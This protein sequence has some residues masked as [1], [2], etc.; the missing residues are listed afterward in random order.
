M[1]AKPDEIT[2]QA[3]LD[4]RTNHM[5][6]VNHEYQRGGV[7]TPAQK[8]RLIDSVL[9]GYPLPLI[10]F[11]YIEQQAAGFISQRLEVI[12][13][14]QRINAL[15]DYRD[16][17]FKLFDP[18]EDEAA[19]RFPDFIKKQPCAWGRKSFDELS[20]D[21]KERFLATPLQ[22]V[23]IEADNANEARDLFVRLQAGMPLTSQEK[24]DAWPGQF[25]DFILKLAGKPQVARYPGEAFFT[26]LMSA[27]KVQDRGKFRQLAAQIAM[28][29]LRRHRDD[30]FCDI[31][32]CQ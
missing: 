25:T 15:A 17:A 13:G 8:K 20:S 1:Q 23:K 11:H 10:Y 18:K 3:L 7:W 31:P 14:Q 6:V 12:D 29:Y 2:I 16:G 5:L 4:L 28:L 27:Q 21:L 22:I 26:E 19:A 24:R 30:V 9:R 32:L